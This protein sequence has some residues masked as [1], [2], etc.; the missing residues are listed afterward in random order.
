MLRG[1]G[2]GSRGSWLNAHSIHST[3]W[4]EPTTV[5]SERATSASAIRISPA[6]C[7]R[8]SGSRASAVITTRSRSGGIAGAHTEGG[9]MTRWRRLSS[10]S[11]S[12]LPSNSRRPASTSWATTP[13]ANRST[14]ESMLPVMYSGAM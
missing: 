3:T 2:S 12:S 10:V 1:S 6:V 5:P 9:W 11:K 14:R 8:W 7:Q 13:I 4:G